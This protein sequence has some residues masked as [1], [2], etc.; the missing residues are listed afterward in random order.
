MEGRNVQFD[1]R[2]SSGDANRMRV[3]AAD[4]VEQKPDVILVNGVPG[5]AALLKETARFQS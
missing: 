2:W 5:A 1:T 3:H 4:L